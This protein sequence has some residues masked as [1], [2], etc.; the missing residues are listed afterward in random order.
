[1]AS[2]DTSLAHEQDCRCDECVKPNHTLGPWFV[3][4]GTKTARVMAKVHNGSD[5]QVALLGEDPVIDQHRFL[6][7]AHLCAAAPDLLAACEAM[8]GENMP[9]AGEPGHIDFADAVQM[10]RT[11]LRKARGEA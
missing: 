7:D 8:L 9:R 10:A 3:K 11:A 5:Y 2:T 6:A 4:R 1:M